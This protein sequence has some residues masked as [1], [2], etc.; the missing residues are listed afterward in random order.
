MDLINKLIEGLVFI[1]S[2]IAVLASIA[3]LKFWEKSRGLRKEILFS[4]T[5][6]DRVIHFNSLVC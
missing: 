6:C 4:K 1:L 5:I 3:N 2:I